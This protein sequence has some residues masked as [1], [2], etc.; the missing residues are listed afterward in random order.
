LSEEVQ[1]YCEEIG[2][3]YGICPELLMAIIEA[4][5]S[6]NQ[7]AEN[8]SCKGLMQVSV[9]WHADRMEKLGVTDIYDEY[10]N[11]LVATD[12][13]A[14]L[15]ED[16]GEVSCVLDIYNGNSKAYYNYENGILSVY[17]KSVLERSAE[18]ERLRGN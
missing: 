6:G 10:G 5:S 3:M 11:I 2:E 13:I 9:R 12:Y 7:Y 1:G 16:Y 18:L 8:G 14:E 17:A 4:E 15:R